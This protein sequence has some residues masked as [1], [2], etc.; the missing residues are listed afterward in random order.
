MLLP[1][2]DQPHGESGGSKG[3]HH[4]NQTNQQQNHDFPFEKIHLLQQRYARW[5]K[6]ECHV[7][8]QEISLFPDMLHLEHTAQQQYKQQQH[9]QDTCRKRKGQNRG[10]PLP[11]QADSKDDSNLD[12]KLYLQFYHPIFCART[13]G[14]LFSSQTVFY[15][16]TACGV[17]Q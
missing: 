6:E 17:A 4:R 7:F 5:D 13:E 9:T 15:Y 10:N 14:G 3:Q 11:Y 16:S 12:Q 8:Q 2:A 1:T